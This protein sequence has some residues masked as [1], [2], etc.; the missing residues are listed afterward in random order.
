MPSPWQECSMPKRECQCRKGEPLVE[1]ALSSTLGNPAR[2][3]G[4]VVLQESLK[5][6]IISVTKHALEGQG[7]A[8]MLAI[9]YVLIETIAGRTGQALQALRGVKGIT[10]VD[11]V[12]G[13]YNIIA[14]VHGSD[15]NDIGRLVREIDAV[16][17]VTRIDT[18][19]VEAG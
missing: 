11:A 8:K 6:E 18:C 1:I 3:Q 7:G 16:D 10:S 19:M 14:I 12:T 5:C 13:Q 9:A 2:R 17:G 15:P 4:N